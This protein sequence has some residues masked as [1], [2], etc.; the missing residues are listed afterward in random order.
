MFR[1]QTL[2][3]FLVEA[4]RISPEVLVRESLCLLHIF[5]RENFAGEIGFE[6]VLQAGHFGMIEE[7]AAGTDVGVDVARVSRILPPVGQLVAVGGED[8]VEAQRLDVGSYWIA[9][10]D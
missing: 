6:D 9:T 7:A 8:R 3:A 1:V 2:P 10:N 4:F 5:E